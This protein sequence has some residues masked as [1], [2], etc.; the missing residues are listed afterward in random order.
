MRNRTHRGS[1]TEC[2]GSTPARG[3]LQQRL[4]RSAQ[5]WPYDT[6]AGRVVYASKSPPVPT[7]FCPAIRGGVQSPDIIQR[8]LISTT[9]HKDFV[10]YGTVMCARHGGGP[11]C[12]Y[13]TKSSLSHP[14]TIF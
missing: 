2:P 5:D 14:T 11:W 9:E 13:T 10:L 6:R 12:R 3:Y 7:S 8:L 4:T 1:D